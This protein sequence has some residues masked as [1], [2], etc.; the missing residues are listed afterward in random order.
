MG[1]HPIFESDFDCLTE[2]LDQLVPVLTP[3]EII[4]QLTPMEATTTIIPMVAPMPKTGPTRTTLLQTAELDGTTTA[5]LAITQVV[6]TTDP[7]TTDTASRSLSM[8]D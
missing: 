7:L 8:I 1:T 4:T 6:T 5:T 3:T 2:C